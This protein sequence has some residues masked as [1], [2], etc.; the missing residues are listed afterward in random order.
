MQNPGVTREMR[1]SWKVCT[2]HHPHWDQL[3]GPVSPFWPVGP[4][5]PVKSIIHVYSGFK[6]LGHNYVVHTYHTF[7][8]AFAIH[9]HSGRNRVYTRDRGRMHRSQHNLLHFEIFNFS[10]GTF[11]VN[12][13]GVGTVAA[14]AALTATL[15]RP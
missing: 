15:F 12:F 14:V 8:F 3:G 5:S 10:S 11:K 4:L 6:L 1:M 7:L 2:L 13:S 9:M